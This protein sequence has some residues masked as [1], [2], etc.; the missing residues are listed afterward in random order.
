MLS[1]II[2]TDD[3]APALQALLMAL[4]P[5]AV[6]GLVREVIAADAGSSDRTLELADDAG[7]DVV[8]GG[9]VLAAATARNPWV[10]VLPVQIRLPKD[11]AARLSVHM[12]RGPRPGLLKSAQAW[13]GPV[14]LL[15]AREV[16]LTASETRDVAFL[17]RS[18]GRGLPRL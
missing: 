18:L 17:V 8:S 6:D 11:W 4:A 3:S 5:A 7:V 10:L 16:L 1:V 13:F 12:G 14:G 9:L 15:V 2:P